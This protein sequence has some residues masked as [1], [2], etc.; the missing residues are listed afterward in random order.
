MR[1]DVFGVREGGEIDG[2]LIA[3]LRPHVPTLEPGKKYL[4]ETVIRT[5]KL[6]HPFTQGTVDSNEVWLDVIVKSGDR[7]IGRSGAMD[8]R[9]RKRS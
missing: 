4:I 5:V 9:A 1:V 7:V 2:K 3:P 8:P 6:G